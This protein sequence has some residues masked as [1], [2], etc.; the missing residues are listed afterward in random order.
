MNIWN[1]F[2]Y[3]LQR[4]GVSTPRVGYQPMAVNR[5]DS[6]S[7]GSSMTDWENGLSTVRRKASKMAVYDS[8]CVDPRLTIGFSKIAVCVY[9]RIIL[10]LWAYGIKLGTE[11]VSSGGGVVELLEGSSGSSSKL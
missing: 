1:Q 2:H 4:P 10:R 9:G 11:G 6:S 8:R 5:A 3:H 7:S